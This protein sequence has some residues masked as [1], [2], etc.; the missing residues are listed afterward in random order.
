MNLSDLLRF[1]LQTTR[2]MNEREY[3]ALLQREKNRKRI[4]RKRILSGR[5]AELMADALRVLQ[6]PAP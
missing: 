1:P 6:W 3:A 5:D 4:K 2:P